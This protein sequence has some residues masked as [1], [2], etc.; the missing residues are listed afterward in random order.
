MK[1]MELCADES[2]AGCSRACPGLSCPRA[3]WPGRAERPRPRAAGPPG[4]MPLAV[5]LQT[6]SSAATSEPASC[7]DRTGPD[8]TDSESLRLAA[9]PLPRRPGPS[10][11]TPLGPPGRTAGE[12]EPVFIFAQSS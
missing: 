9:R 10:D 6:R 5:S 12:S 1:L 7:Y 2:E 8:G 11:L 3:A 4:I